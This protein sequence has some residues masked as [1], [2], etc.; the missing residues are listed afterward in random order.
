M[1]NHERILSALD[2][3]TKPNRW[4][5]HGTAA[6]AFALGFEDAPDK[7]A[8]SN[9]IDAVLWIGQADKLARTYY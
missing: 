9:D 1:N 3:G 2:G 5:S 8:Q 4:S 7:F 6:A